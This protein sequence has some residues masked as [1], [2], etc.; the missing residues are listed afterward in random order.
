MFKFEKMIA[1]QKGVDLVDQAFGISDNWPQRYQF[2]LGEQLRRAA[3]SI[4]NNLAEGSGRISPGHRRNFYDSAKG[5]V[6]EVVSILT[7]ANKRNLVDREVL[8]RLYQH[9][10]ELASI[11]SG[12]IESTLR[13]ENTPRTL[14]DD[15]TD[16]DASDT[17]HS[18]SNSPL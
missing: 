8:N 12:L 7:I 14:R 4:T 3:L 6:Y 15:T 13:E 17:L 1:W 10:D 5:S 9:A 16:Y 11:I 18:N 2:S